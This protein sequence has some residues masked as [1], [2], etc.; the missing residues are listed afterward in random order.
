MTRLLGIDLGTRRIGLA[1]AEA[2]PGA[3][4][5]ATGTG[6]AGATIRPLATISRG[7]ALR[8]ATTIARICEE[9][10]I[11]EIVVGLPLS[12]RGDEAAMAVS[13]RA[14]AEAVLGPLGL[15]VSWRDE[16]LTTE[17]AAS[18]L[19]APRRGRSGGAP[20]AAQR[21][22]HRASLDRE[23]AAIILQAELDARAAAPATA[24]D[25]GAVPVQ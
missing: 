19:P 12:L 18:R 25:G 5:G 10:R 22:A 4:G 7:T 21:G 9:Q 3:A 23:A 6:A 16:R 1:V 15:P 24:R 8:D 13:A 14:W 20:S 17:R 2:G 11:D